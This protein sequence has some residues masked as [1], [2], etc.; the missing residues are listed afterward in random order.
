M[1]RIIILLILSIF[2]ITLVGC[3]ETNKKVKIDFN[4]DDVS[5]ILEV[6]KGTTITADIIPFEIEIENIELYYDKTKNKKYDGEK[7]NTDTTIYIIEKENTEVKYDEEQL[8]KDYLAYAISLGEKSLTINDVR[9]LNYY[10]QYNNSFIVKMDR[11]AYQVFTY[12]TFPEL[13]IEF[14]FSDTNTPLV[15][16]AGEFYELSNAYYSGVLT[17]DNLIELQEKLK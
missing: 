4:K 5:K 7:I 2:S 6:D 14:E 3:K 17:K 11:G 16:N 1:K 15:Y 8:K 12:V 13:K 9:V 10:G